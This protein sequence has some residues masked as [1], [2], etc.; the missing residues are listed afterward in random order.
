MFKNMHRPNSAFCAKSGQVLLLTALS[1]VLFVG[2]TAL[3][4]DA[5][6]LYFQKDRL[7]TAVNAGYKAGLD[8]MMELGG[9]PLDDTKKAAIRARVL[10]VMGLNG[11]SPA[12]LTSINITFP[13]NHNLDV[14]DQKQ[15][16]LFF[17][18]VV[19]L[20]SAAVGAG[21]SGLADGLA[22]PIPLAI[23]FGVTR[24]IDKTTYSV[25]LFPTNGTADGFV[26]GTEY[27][28][29]LGGS[30]PGN[31]PNTICRLYVPMGSGDQP[32]V[33]AFI[34]A[35][36]V[37]HWA[38]GQT[39]FVPVEW[40]VGDRGGGGSFMF[41]YSTDPAVEA[42]KHFSYLLTR[43][44]SRGINCYA[45]TGAQANAIYDAVD[46]VI[47][48]GQDTN[49]IQLRLQPYIKIYSS[50]ST[51]DPVEKILK[52]AEIPYG[53]TGTGASYQPY[54]LGLIGVG[55]TFDGTRCNHLFDNE[56][57]AGELDNG[58]D[59]LH[60]HHEDFMGNDEGNNVGGTSAENT[61]ARTKRNASGTLYTA[62]GSFTAYQIVKQDIAY[63]IRLFMTSGKM[64]YTQCF[65]TESID[66]ALWLRRV[67]LG[68]AGDV[69][70]DC[71]AFTGFNMSTTNQNVSGTVVRIEGTSAIVSVISPADGSTVEV[72]VAYV[73][74]HDET[75][76]T[77]NG[78]VTSVNTSANTA[79]VRV[80]WPATLSGSTV[81]IS[82]NKPGGGTYRR[83]DT[84]TNYPYPNTTTIPGSPAVG[85]AR[86]VSI[87]VITYNRP[88][89]TINTNNAGNYSLSNALD[90]RQQNH[91]RSGLNGFSG[92]CSSFNG[93]LV[94][95]GVN[96]LGSID[97]GTSKKY[98]SGRV[99]LGEFAF[100][101]GHEGNIYAQ[102]L[103]L[104]NVL[105]G[106]V[107]KEL[108]TL[109]GGGRKR[110]TGIID[111][112]NVAG[113]TFDQYLNAFKY[114]SNITTQINDRILPLPGIATEATAS[115]VD[116]RLNGD[117]SGTPPMASYPRVIIAITDL[118]PEITQAG[119]LNA[120]ATSIY[121]LQGQDDPNGVYATSAFNF[122]SAVRIIGY[123]EFEL[124]P[125]AEATDADR[126]LV[127]GG[128]QEGQ[129]RGRFIRYI[130][131]PYE[132]VIPQ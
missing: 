2:L 105:Y 14:T 67:R 94:K 21:R 34:K 90:P 19:N 126:N 11:Y 39:D 78:T 24:D 122:T 41:R 13:G 86:T 46:T 9:P 72:P 63:K 45:K 60:L 55:A 129:V 119:A 128:T 71:L 117:P 109:G 76:L 101:G 82:R 127:I 53:G 3:V 29:K 96:V 44:T 75:T 70:S 65:A 91:L 73:A 84:V 50:Q 85:T 87:P 98:L 12:E 106:S 118:G 80:S 64:M 38:L 31:D 62:S 100:M 23:P 8:R 66:G 99:D 102:R 57:L 27:I 111:P 112:A 110:N 79:Q 123:A 54:K 108:V 56:I 132:D 35:Y 68:L 95:N 4:T 83:N 37:A 124:I 40:L 36:G 22:V 88:F 97:G 30:D 59:W 130:V 26:P 125:L 120:T 6:Y 92:L 16:G 58:A 32:S 121:D 74:A 61:W 131:K 93:A 115:G 89:T 49:I 52:A 17:A 15:V 113:G 47:P 42:V 10:E 81:T 25:S 20:R 114:G 18:S 33:T 103:V 77:I 1:M 69:Y 104:N 5:G 7:T 107:Q 48:P 116:F 28:L 43:L 51:D